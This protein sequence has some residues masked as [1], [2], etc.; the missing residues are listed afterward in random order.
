MINFTLVFYGVILGLIISLLWLLSCLWPP[1]SP[2]SPWW[3]TLKSTAK[4]AAK[5]GKIEESDIVYELGSGDGEFLLYLAKA[6]H[7]KKGIG[8]EIDPFRYILA[9]VRKRILN[10]PKTEL[11]FVRKN[12][13][14]VNLSEATVVYVYLVPAALNRL[15]PKFKKELKQ[16][17]RIISYRY[18]MDLPLVAKG[19]KSDRYPI[20]LYKL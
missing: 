11:H 8:V 18:E 17:T 13:F 15:L 9:N 4:A 12:F 16:G 6:L 7:I 2:W 19:E 10:V 20:F 3:K 1:D 5:L 14:D